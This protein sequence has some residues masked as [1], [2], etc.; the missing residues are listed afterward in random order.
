MRKQTIKVAEASADKDFGSRNHLKTLVL[1]IATVLGVYLCYRMVVPFLSVITWALTLAVLFAPLQHRLEAKLKNANLATMF[2]VLIIGLIVVVP[3]IFVGQQLVEQAVNG[4]KLLEMR[5]NS[6]EWRQSIK[7]Q[8]YVIP[9]LD[10]ID[11]YVDLPG[12][13]RA[14]TAWLGSAAGFIVKGSVFQVLG[15]C[16]VLYILFF[17]LR[18]RHL[19]L[20]SILFLSPLT[21]TEMNK[22]FK[23]VADTLYATVYG[24]FAVA[25]IQGLLGGLMFMW[26]DLPA[27]LLWG[28]IM[29]MLA[30]VPMLGA[31]IIWVP[32]ALFL[33]LQGNWDSAVILTL[34]GMLVVGT[35][36]NILRPIL[37]GNR[38]KLH[39][40]LIFLS[41]V[42]GLILFGPAGVVLG[43]VV[44]T[45]TI[46]L[47]EIWFNRNAEEAIPS[48]E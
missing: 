2:S 15:L 9:I 19:V 31:F 10:R 44:L 29:G 42:G 13:V 48:Q 20:K 8:Q 1:M 22:L 12:A 17:F 33:A 47:L 23:R 41:V 28:L 26:L 27:P 3:L 40:V 30:I 38:L 4:T 14:F 35:V 34:W 45:I 18:D 36:D 6:G 5:L 46:V 25:A 37:V 39:T 7:A 32:A 21:Q 24:S 11:Q 43:P 16:L